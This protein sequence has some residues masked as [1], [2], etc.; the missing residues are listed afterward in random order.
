MS[1]NNSSKKFSDAVRAMNESFGIAIS[2]SLAA[3]EV[4]TF[5]MPTGYIAPDSP[6]LKHL[7]SFRNPLI[8]LNEALLSEIKKLNSSIDSMNQ[9]IHDLEIKAIQTEKLNARRQW[10]IAIVSTLIGAVAGSIMTIVVTL[11]FV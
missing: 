8:D 1:D 11:L 4:P 7:A 5:R 10:T 9:Q 6:E 2:K 3:I